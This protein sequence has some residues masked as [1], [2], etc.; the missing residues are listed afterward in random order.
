[1]KIQQLKKKNKKKNIQLFN[2]ENEQNSLSASS[3]SPSEYKSEMK[4]SLNFLDLIEEKNNLNKIK[5]KNIGEMCDN[6]NNITLREIENEEYLISQFL[7]K[8]NEDEKLYN[9]YLNKSN[10]RDLD[11]SNKMNKDYC[12][13]KSREINNKNRNEDESENSYNTTDNIKINTKDHYI[14]E[15]IIDEYSTYQNCEKKQFINEN[16]SIY[17]YLDNFDISVEFSSN[18]IKE[19]TY[20]KLLAEIHEFD[21][22]N[23]DQISIINKIVFIWQN[24]NKENIF[25]NFWILIEA[26]ESLETINILKSSSFM[27]NIIENLYLI[28]EILLKIKFPISELNQ[29]KLYR[30]NS[31]LTYLL[32]LY[33]NLIKINNCSCI[34][35]KTDCPHVDSLSN[36]IVINTLNSS[37]IIFI[38]LSLIFKQRIIA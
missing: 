30:V 38:L 33:I 34:T 35:S 5:D 28:Y 26:K 15:N 37:K 6:N 3:V 10:D 1:M 14:C 9:N 11:N 2:F 27:N 32:K 29:S 22:K 4:K 24:I 8:Y 13:K 7:N 20:N 21:N 18:V 17:L 31:E 19:F 36:D 16:K 23:E 25:L 12:N